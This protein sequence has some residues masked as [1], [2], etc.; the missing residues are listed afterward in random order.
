MASSSRFPPS[1]AEAFPSLPNKGKSVVPNPWA[2][3]FNYQTPGFA[4]SL[5]SFVP[6]FVDGHA[7]VPQE[8]IDQGLEVWKD[9]AVGF[10]IDRKLPY[11]LVK[12]S[13]TKAWKLGADFEMITDKQL[14]YFKFVSEE[15]KR[16]VIEMGPVFIVGR[17][18]IISNWSPEIEAQRDYITSVPIW[19]KILDLPKEL[20]TDD[21]ISY[22]ASLIG[23]PKCM[24]ELTA[25]RKRLSFARVCVEVDVS[26]E[27]P[28]TISLKIGQKFYICKVEYPWIPLSCSKCKRFGHSDKKCHSKV[29]TAWKE[30]VVSSNE[31]AAATTADDGNT[32]SEKATATEE[33]ETTE[34]L[35]VQEEPMLK[36]GVEDSIVKGMQA[37]NNF[38][39]AV[40]EA[41]L[42]IA[43]ET[44]EEVEVPNTQQIEVVPDTQFTEQ[45]KEPTL[46]EEFGKNKDNFVEFME[47]EDDDLSEEEQEL[48]DDHII[49]GT[50]EDPCL[51]QFSDKMRAKTKMLEEH[52][53]YSSVKKKKRGRPKGTGKKK[54]R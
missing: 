5:S 36:Q 43:M 40:F 50:S 52:S 31:Q 18:F 23:N 53:P 25:K 2:A 15:D 47:S 54:T 34:E 44:Y 30:K 19:A 46:M 14:Y 35:R 9:Y 26:R 11:K 13:L 4:T 3:L 21:G 28:K 45:T 38:Q 48:F 42:P 16:K 33:S 32:C 39:L 8:L 6:T 22:A 29:S 7:D 10:F 1:M 41:P 51:M 20:W 27:L 49:L 17:V 12:D 24:D 37:T